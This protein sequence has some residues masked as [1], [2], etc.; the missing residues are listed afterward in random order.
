ME[1]LATTP[2]AKE[3]LSIITTRGVDITLTLMMVTGVYTITHPLDTREPTIRQ[4]TPINIHTLQ[5]LALFMEELSIF[6][7]VGLMVM[8]MW[9]TVTQDTHMVTQTG[10]T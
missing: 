10:M 7:Q 1:N 4:I 2:L 8:H 9:L 3:T 6:M 5:Q